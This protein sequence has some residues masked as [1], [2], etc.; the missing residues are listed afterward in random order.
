MKIVSKF[1]VPIFHVFFEKKDVKERY[2]RARLDRAGLTLYLIQLVLKWFKKCIFIFSESFKG[3]RA[4]VFNIAYV[5]S[6]KQYIPLLAYM[7]TKPS[8]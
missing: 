6:M 7:R 2:G 1:Q 8:S 5:F 4:Y 3:F